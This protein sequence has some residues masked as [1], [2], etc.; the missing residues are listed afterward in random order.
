M[1]I[2][3]EQKARKINVY[4]NLRAIIEKNML[5]MDSRYHMQAVLLIALMIVC[6]VTLTICNIVLKEWYLLIDTGIFLLYSCLL[7]C[8]NLC[9]WKRIGKRISFLTSIPIWMLITPYFC[10]APIDATY[11]YWISFIPV[12][13]IS[14]LGLKKGW[15]GGIGIFVISLIFLVTP[16]RHAIPYTQY[17]AIENYTIYATTFILTAILSLT[18][19]FSVTVFNEIIIQKLGA[20][21]EEYYDASMMDKLTGL[22]NQMKFSQF[23]EK[24][25]NNY[26]DGDVIDIMFIDVDDFKSINDT[27]GHLVGND[28]LVSLAQV[29]KEDKH[30]MTIRWGG[31]EFVIIEKNKTQDELVREAN[32]LI[33][34]VS[35]IRHPKHPDLKVTI[36]VGLSIQKIDENFSFDR[37]INSADRQV[38][39]AKREGKNTVR[40]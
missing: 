18:L 13:I 33:T 25:K 3:K 2:P 40:I 34:R 8:A 29:F 36:S 20:L 9:C 15:W 1:S 22:A 32:D 35:Q 6:G 37:F 24:L 7:F 30:E 17:V 5:D 28:T 31:D 39:K 23:I 26:V 16:I 21:E 38:N 11:T 27:Y 4:R 19:G 10:I 12:L 14:T